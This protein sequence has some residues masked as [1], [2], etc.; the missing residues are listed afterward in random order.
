MHIYHIFFIH[1]SV[2]AHLA[3]FHV[4]AIVKSATVHIGMHVSFQ[5]MAFSRYMPRNGIAGSYRNSIFSFLRNLCTALHSDCTSLYVKK[6]NESESHS[7]MSNSLRPHG[8]DSPWNSVGQNIGVGS[9][10]LLQGIFPTQGSNWSLLYCR[11]ILYQLS[12]QGSP[13]YM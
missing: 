7:V 13:V 10:S 8:L 2:D 5:I 4:L 3:C 9:L 1:S 12:H 6:E 11:Q